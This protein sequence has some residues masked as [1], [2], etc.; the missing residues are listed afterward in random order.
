MIVNPIQ[1]KPKQLISLFVM[2]LISINFLVAQDIPIQSNHLVHN[3]IER[4]VT[5]GNISQNNIAVRPF[6]YSYV[7]RALNDLM[8]IEND[9]SV[10]DRQ[11]LNRFSN[12]FSVTNFDEKVEFPLS[13]SNLKQI[14][15]AAFSN[16][17]INESEPHFVSYRDSSLYAW[18]DINETIY[19]NTIDESLFRRYT[20]DIS[21]FGSISNDL[22]FFI[23]LTMNRFI[24]DS[25][26]VYQLEDYKNEDNPYFDFMN[27]TIW[28]QSNAAFNVKTKYGNI[29]LA[30]IPMIWG[31]SPEHSPILSGSTQTFPFINYSFKNKYVGFQF[32]HGS[33]LSYKSTTIHELE[34]Y[35]QKYLAAHR[36]E[37]YLGKDFTF[38]FNELVIYGDRPFEVEY[39]IPVNFYWPAEHNQGDKDNLLMALDCSWRIL[40]GF[41]WYNTLFWDE[42]AWEKMF[43]K[44]WGNKFVFQSGIHWVAR[45]NPYLIDLRVEGTISRPWTYTH[46]E[47]VNSYASAEIGLGLPQGPN[48]QSLLI[49]LGVWPN[50]RWNMV[51]ETVLLKKGVELGSSV[52]DNYKDRDR[53][54]DE[55][56]PF[57]LGEI[58]KS[59]VFSIKTNYTIN[60]VF[61]LFG[62]FGIDLP[63][64]ELR[65]YLGVNIDW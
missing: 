35:P 34:E 31:F 27:W 32:L 51:F 19:L 52:L 39:L 8:K 46:E 63:D 16:F 7:K 48:S 33:L 23:N 37:F 56:T 17:D 43:S 64:S 3:F 59:A 54:L 11:L 45:S 15:K 65:G 29:Q 61:E 1:N 24:G 40:P 12:E 20:D 50:Y 5:L 49:Q 53:D 25:S 47:F 14:G 38:S 60:R 18:A 55:N 62:Q 4:H 21:I 2:I 26:L 6:T 9:L 41:R 22:S 36:I 28:Y 58:E 44:W 42:L 30:K 13:K 10:K 57:L